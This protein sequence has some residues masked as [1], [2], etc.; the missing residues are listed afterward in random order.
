MILIGELRDAET[1][2]TALQ[3]AESGHLV[4][5][6]LHTIDAAETVGRMIE[7]FPPAKQ[8]LIRSILAGVLRGVISQRL[9][10]RADGGRIAAVEVMV[11]NAR[12]ADLI[13]EDRRRRDH[14]AI[15]EGEFLEMQTFSQSLIDLVIAGVV[16]GRSPRT[17]QRTATTSSS[18]RAGREGTSGRSSR[19]EDS[20]RRRRRL[21]EEARRSSAEPATRTAPNRSVPR[22]SS[23]VA[24]SGHSKKGSRR[25]RQL[26]ML[27]VWPARRCP[28]V[29]ADRSALGSEG[30]FTL[31]ET[32]MAIAI[33]V[34]LIVAVGGVLTSS[35]AAHAVARERTGAEQCVNAQVEAIRAKAY[36]K[37]GTPSG[38][39]P[40]RD[41]R[42]RARAAASTP[43][44][45]SPSSTSTIRRRRAMRP[46]RTTRR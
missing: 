24:D 22:I 2:Q 28:L 39:P 20:A 3:A 15:A 9:L 10:P 17:R 1:A 14:D 11:T 19:G 34:T 46:P 12:I 4:L 38:N 5:S 23:R 26:P 44:P 35:V 36:D 18:P 30:G 8:Q 31:V 37:V 13:R 43:P 41:S 16:D 45:T 21:K 27:S 42:P 29:F 25:A 32:L 40:G 6:T 7:F 33:L